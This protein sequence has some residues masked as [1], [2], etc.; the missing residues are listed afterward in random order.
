MPM[1][2][3]HTQHL[4]AS[5]F[6]IEADTLEAAIERVEDEV[7]VPVSTHAVDDTFE[8]N[9]QQTKVVNGDKDA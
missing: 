1:F 2:T 6:R 9:L 3:V 8:I 5:E 4:V 7:F